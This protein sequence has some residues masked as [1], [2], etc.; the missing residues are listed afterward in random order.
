VPSEHFTHE[1]SHRFPLLVDN[2]PNSVPNI[3]ILP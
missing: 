3:L 2:I 1:K